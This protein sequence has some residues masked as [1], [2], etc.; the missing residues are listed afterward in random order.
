LFPGLRAERVG[1]E[2]LKEI[3]NVNMEKENLKHND[4]VKFDD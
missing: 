3:I 2:N 1:Y 4:E